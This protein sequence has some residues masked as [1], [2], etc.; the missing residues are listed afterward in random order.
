MTIKTRLRLNTVISLGVVILILFSL[1]WSFNEVSGASRN[2]ALV[3]EM[4]NVA[5][6][7]IILRD[8]YLLYREARA[9]T[10]WN[11]KSETFRRLLSSASEIFTGSQD[12]ALLKEA[13][14]NFDATFTS[15]TM[16]MERHKKDEGS[17]QMGINFTE[18]DS[19]LIG[20]VFLRA[21]A[22]RDYIDRL[23]ASAK[24]A[25]TTAQDRGLLLILVSIIGGVL[26]IIINSA[27]IGRT[28][29]TRVS[30]LGKGVE[31]IGAGNL[32]HRI[33][34]K[35][36]DELS[37]L[38]IA[39]NEMAAK[40]QS[41][42]VALERE[43]EDRK[44]ANKELEAFSYSVSHDLRTP[45]RAINGFSRAVLEDYADKLDDE[46]RRLLNVIS[47]NAT[48]MGHLIY[49][50]LAFS[51]I[52]R[53]ELKK[54]EID[55]HELVNSVAQELKQTASGRIIQID[56]KP[57]PAT[58]GDASMIRQ[59]IL[60]LLSNAIKFSAPKNSIA[61]EFG[62]RT[63]GHENVYYVKDQGVGFDMRFA[64]KLFGVF[65]RLHSQ[66]DFEGT[67]VGLALVQRIV[68]RH[69]GRIWAEGKVNE[70]ATF[71]FTLQGMR[72]A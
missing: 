4:Q 50:L 45:L 21:Y 7:R 60:N 62:C 69:G 71:Y 66:E 16:F 48:K 5:F 15:F 65:Q 19:R 49:D 31:I 6:E 1:V 8:D 57:M 58:M 23:Y 55:M 2:L 67:G 39:S 22:L 61:I 14:V 52:G 51:R 54:Q 17:S 64:D 41:S 68:H 30:I 36:D 44:L 32:D 11:A 12:Q 24:T 27:I 46:G 34:V 20:Q 18:T 29:A 56:I 42:Y 47:S 26:A 25:M 9:R 72:E 70:G 33:T 35:G 28:L 40:L 3:D 38:A 13:Q 37:A 59:L 53:L 10:Q 43:S 63:E